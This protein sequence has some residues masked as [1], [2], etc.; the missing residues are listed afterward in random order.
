MTILL[1]DVHAFLDARKSALEDTARVDVYEALLSSVLK[2][3]GVNLGK[4][5]FVRGSSFQTSPAYTLDL[6][7][8]LNRVT[9]KGASHA[10]AD[11]VKQ[12]DNP[13]LGGLVYP[14]MQ[15]LDEVHLAPN[16]DFEL[17]G[18]D[19]RK[20]FCFSLDHLPRRP[21][22]F[23]YIMNP[24]LP[25]LRRAASAG[26]DA[27]GKMSSSETVG[28]ID[29]LDT[30]REIGKKVGSAFC[31]EGDVDDNSL[32]PLCRQVIFPCLKRLG[33]PFIVTRPEKFGAQVVFTCFDELVALFREGKLHPADL[34]R[35]M[36]AA[37]AWILEPIRE[38]WASEEKKTLLGR[39][40]PA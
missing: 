6:L 35:E 18:V 4:V 38:E 10:G 1:A 32:L 31:Q 14:L 9:V 7:R 33:K 5:N 28:K 26:E 30:P 3:L 19:Q 39:A 17:G 23:S 11:V 34:K 24:M 21:D 37:L 29:L 2:R 16:L 27:A 36:T 15:S 25:A 40:Y 12:S 8:L 22:G 20:I 13:L